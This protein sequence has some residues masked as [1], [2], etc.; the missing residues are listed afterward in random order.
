ML[1]LNKIQDIAVKGSHP[2]QRS[3]DEP[4]RNN[5][6]SMASLHSKVSGAAMVSQRFLNEQRKIATDNQKLAHHI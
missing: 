5:L 1:L 4:P 6:Q 2:H 3:V